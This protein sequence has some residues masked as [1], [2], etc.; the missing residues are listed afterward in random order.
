M[1]AVHEVVDL[2]RQSVVVASE[3]VEER[4]FD[5]E[6]GWVFIDIDWHVILSATVCYY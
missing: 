6:R 5:V 4:S 1:A 2:Q 3:R